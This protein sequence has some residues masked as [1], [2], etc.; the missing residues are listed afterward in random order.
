MINVEL[1]KKICEIFGVL[2]YEQCIWEFVFVEVILFVDK[3]EVDVM[4]NVLVI[5]KG[6]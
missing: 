2:G 1:F 3:V 5:K 6:Q 4:G